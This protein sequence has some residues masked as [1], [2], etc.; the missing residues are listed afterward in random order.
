MPKKSLPYSKQL[1]GRLTT[2][3][4]GTRESSWT[5]PPI[6]NVRRPP[7]ANPGN[8]REAGTSKI[9]F[10]ILVNSI[11][12]ME[13]YSPVDIVVIRQPINMLRERSRCPL[14]M[15]CCP[16]GYNRFIVLLVTI[17]ENPHD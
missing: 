13:T 8:A 4:K 3:A 7:T 9:H 14:K 10:V 1:T 2:I 16:I 11:I 12:L 5:L 15:M 6:A 17:V